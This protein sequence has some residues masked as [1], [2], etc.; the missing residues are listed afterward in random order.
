MLLAPILA[1]FNRPDIVIADP[2]NGTPMPL[3]GHD[4]REAIEVTSVGI[5]NFVRTYKIPTAVWRDVTSLKK[6]SFIINHV[7]KPESLAYHQ[8]RLD[9]ALPEVWKGKVKLM[10]WEEAPV[11]SACGYDLKVDFRA[12][13]PKNATADGMSREGI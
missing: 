7:L 5:Y 13:Y 12:Q 11:C 8:F 3:R 1:M 4:I 2:N 10:N 9:Q 6:R